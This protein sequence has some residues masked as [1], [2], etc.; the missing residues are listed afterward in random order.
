MFENGKPLFI[1]MNNG[2]YAKMYICTI[3]TK[4]VTKKN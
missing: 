4:T 2:F 3:K 1:L